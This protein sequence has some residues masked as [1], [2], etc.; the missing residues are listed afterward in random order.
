MIMNFK[1]DIVA[2]S[3]S[4]AGKDIITMSLTYPR[5]IHSELMTHRVFSRNAMSSRAVP[6]AK[7]IEQV[8]TNPAAPIHWG[9]NKPGMQAGEES[10][11][12]D[13]AA[14]REYWNVAAVHATNIAE[15]MMNMGLHKQ[16]VN[17]IL[18]PFQWMHTLVT[19]TEW[20]NFFNLRLS[21][22][23]QP[24]FRHLAV[25]MSEAQGVSQPVLTDWHLPYITAD[26]IAKGFD[27][28]E[29]CL[30]SAAR[31]ARVSYLNHDGS[32]PNVEKDLVLA[33]TLKSSG[34]ASPFEHQALAASFVDAASRNFKGWHQFRAIISL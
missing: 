24:E 34:H 4:P 19:S 31:C 25:M 12:H 33:E 29:L 10:K 5:F 2:H 17:R 22:M 18:E 8:R 13:L 30:I 28:H 6:V 32:A 7:M 1:A 15:D 11:G 23:A 14:A 21:P 9:S 16:V 20:D 27:K 3:T 26:D